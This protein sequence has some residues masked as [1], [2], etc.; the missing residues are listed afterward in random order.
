MNSAFT[1]RRSTTRI[2]ICCTLISMKQ[3]L[4]CNLGDTAPSIGHPVH[5]AVQSAFLPAVHYP[6]LRSPRYDRARFRC[7]P[8]SIQMPSGP[9]MSRVAPVFS[10]NVQQLLH[11]SLIHI[12][13]TRQHDQLRWLLLQRFQ[14]IFRNRTERQFQII[15]TLHV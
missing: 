12:M 2:L 15:G 14:M 5:L 9:V 1:D 4:L 10:T 8:V 13:R 6:D 7:L 11:C 3:R